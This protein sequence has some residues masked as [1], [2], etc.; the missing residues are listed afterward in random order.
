MG[1]IDQFTTFWQNPYVMGLPPSGKLALSY[2][3]DLMDENRQVVLEDMALYTGLA[4]TECAYWSE[5]FAADGMVDE[6][7]GPDAADLAESEA[8]LQASVDEDRYQQEQD[9]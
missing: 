3:L 7:D 8:D 6:L 5:K 2:I 1:E 9:G 4:A